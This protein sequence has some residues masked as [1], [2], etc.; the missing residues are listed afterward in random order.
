MKNTLR[1]WRRAIREI[2][3]PS[4][5][6]KYYV[7]YTQDCGYGAAMVCHYVIHATSIKDAQKNWQ[8]RIR[9]DGFAV[10]TYS[11][12]DPG[13]LF[14]VDE[15]LQNHSLADILDFYDPPQPCHFTHDGICSVPT[16]TKGALEYGCYQSSY[17]SWKER[18]RDLL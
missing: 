10:Q 9:A 7:S 3:T 12:Y 13:E 8:D 14:Y 16:C 11:P 6:G 18:W 2:L 15:R 5:K 4:K 17:D 1:H